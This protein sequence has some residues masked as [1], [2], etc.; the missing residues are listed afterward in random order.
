M[1][2][3]ALASSLEIHLSE[4]TRDAAFDRYAEVKARAKQQQ[5]NIVALVAKYRRARKDED[6]R[7]DV[8]NPDLYCLLRQHDGPRA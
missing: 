2:K 6:Q 8:E 5:A 4:N 7:Y 3:A 1:L